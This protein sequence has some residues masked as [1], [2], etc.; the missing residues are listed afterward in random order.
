MEFEQKYEKLLDLYTEKE[1]EY[2]QLS[3]ELD[4]QLRDSYQKQLEVND[5]RKDNEGL[6][7][8]L[9][10][11]EKQLASLKGILNHNMSIKDFESSIEDTR[12]RM[13]EFRPSE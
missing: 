12:S 3:D 8:R 5:L 1:Q 9:M 6:K 13:S 2:F 7:E 10:E 11:S 4:L